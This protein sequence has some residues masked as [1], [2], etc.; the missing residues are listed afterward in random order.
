MTVTISVAATLGQQHT[1]LTEPTKW[2]TWRTYLQISMLFF[3]HTVTKFLTYEINICKSSIH[4]DTISLLL[5]VSAEI[6]L[7]AVYTPVFKTH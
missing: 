4:N 5:H 3:P 6:H 7:Q 2:D 1:T